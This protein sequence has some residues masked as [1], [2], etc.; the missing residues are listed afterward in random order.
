MS[1]LDRELVLG[2]CGWPATTE[3]VADRSEVPRCRDFFLSM[4]WL[5]SAAPPKDQRRGGLDRC[6]GSE[7]PMADK[8][9][10][11]YALAG[12]SHARSF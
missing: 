4:P 10:R 8:N 11:T 7:P 5:A 1:G 6:A 3:A 9:L 2:S 12:T